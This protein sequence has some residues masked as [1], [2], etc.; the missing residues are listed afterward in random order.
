M[1]MWWMEYQPYITEIERGQKKTRDTKAHGSKK[2]VAK[3]FPAVIA[4]KISQQKF[5]RTYIH[6]HIYMYI[7]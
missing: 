2:S 1:D 3:L 7:Q 5:S 6:T 4:A